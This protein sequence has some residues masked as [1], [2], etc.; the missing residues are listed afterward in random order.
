[1]IITKEELKNYLWIT[2]T[3]QDTILSI[4]ANWT[5]DMVESMCGRK[6]EEDTYTAYVDWAGQVDLVLPQ[7]PVKSITSI[8]YNTGT[9][10][11]PIWEPI[12][13]DLYNFNANNWII[14]FDI[15]LARWFGNYKIIYVAWYETIPF[16]LK[17]VTLKLAWMNYNTKWSNG[18]LSESVWGDSITFSNGAIPWDI[19]QVIAKYQNV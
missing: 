5:S 19:L 18:V 6:F 3:T 16:D 10:S 14:S 7:Y 15:Q 2:D 11:T 1:M 8:S 9:Y 4:F 13:N 17:L 12:D